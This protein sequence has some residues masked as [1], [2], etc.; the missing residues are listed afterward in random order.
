[1][2]TAAGTGIPAQPYVETNGFSIASLVLGIVSIF[3]GFTFIVPVVGVVLGVLALKREP[4]SRTM[5]IWGVVLN[6]V[7]LAGA[8]L[9]TVGAL[10]FG[11]VMLPFAF[12]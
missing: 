2:T 1:M 4:A 7:M 12:I 5:A 6:A 10:V 3:A 9:F 11:L 8:A